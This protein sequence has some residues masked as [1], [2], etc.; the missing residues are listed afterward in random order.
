M[1]KRIVAALILCA[2]F[3][4]PALAD[5]NDGLLAFRTKD[6]EGA[7]KQWTPLAEDG[8]PRAQTNL[9]LLYS[10]GLGV[11]KDG[12]KAL[13]WFEKAAQQGYP[14][15]EY[16]L[17]TIFAKGLEVE[18]DQSIATTWYLQAAEHG[19]VRSQFEVARRY[20]EGNGIPFDEVEAYVWLSRAEKKA[21][22]KILEQVSRYKIRLTESMSDE[23]IAQAEALLGDNG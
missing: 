20:A 12:Q 10:R 23:E 22:G 3:V 13:A 19:H 17:A 4:S 2:V 8:D 21:R 11:P 9:G 15:A 7:A 5:F 1:I 14:T 16:N 6:Y 18:K